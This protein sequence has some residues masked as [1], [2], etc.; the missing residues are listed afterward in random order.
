MVMAGGGRLGGW[1]CCAPP[2]DRGAPS[3]ERWLDNVMMRHGFRTGVRWLP[4]AI[5]TVGAMLA[6]GCFIDP[7]AI[8]GEQ[9][10]EQF[11]ISKTSVFIRVIN[12]GESTQVLDLRIDGVLKTLPQC[13]ATTGGTDEGKPWGSSTQM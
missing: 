8:L 9:I 10:S 7:T 12:Q 1:C 6:T 3:V 5:L 4:L 11:G 2:T 13:A